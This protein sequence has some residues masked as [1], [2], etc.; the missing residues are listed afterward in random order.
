M[1]VSLAFGAS[2]A[3]VFLIFVADGTDAG[4]QENRVW[5]PSFGCTPVADIIPENSLVCM[6]P[7]LQ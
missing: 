3:L 1:M 7:A 2:I 6:P 4:W 5:L